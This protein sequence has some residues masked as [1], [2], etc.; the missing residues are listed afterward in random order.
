MQV[1]EAVAM[2]KG[3]VKRA[4]RTQRLSRVM[5]SA[6]LPVSGEGNAGTAAAKGMAQVT[7]KGSGKGAVKDRGR[8]AASACV[9]RRCPAPRD[10]ASRWCRGTR[11]L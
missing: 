11:R 2:S 8:Y 5:Q 4:E 10:S 9:A 3:I 7:G 1:L 6:P